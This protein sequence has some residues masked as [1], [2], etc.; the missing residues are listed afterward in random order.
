VLGLDP[1][2]DHE[3]RAARGTRDQSDVALGNPELIGDE[4]EQRLVRGSI[5]RRRGDAHPQDPVGDPIDTIGTA[6]RRQADGEADVVVAQ[7]DLKGR[8]A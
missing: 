4:A 2:H 5:H 7:D 8:R 3:L 1:V 6:A